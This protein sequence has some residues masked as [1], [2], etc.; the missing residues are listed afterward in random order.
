M[1]F[2][3]L[4]YQ[5][6]R[7]TNTCKVLLGAM[8]EPKKATQTYTGTTYTISQLKEIQGNFR[9]LTLCKSQTTYVDTNT[10]PYRKLF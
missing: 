3:A 5:L 7:S 6:N 4:L 10:V 8:D 1:K 9:F 2:K